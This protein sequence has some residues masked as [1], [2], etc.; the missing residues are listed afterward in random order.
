M[1]IVVVV[2]VFVVTGVTVFVGVITD[3]SGPIFV[4]AFDFESVKS[5]NVILSPL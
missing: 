5:P 4:V 2:V 3:L 1:D